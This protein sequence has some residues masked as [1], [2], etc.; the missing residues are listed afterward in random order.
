MSDLLCERCGEPWEL[1]FITDEMSE[2]ERWDFHSGKGCP[3]CKGKTLCDREYPCHECPEVM[4]GR[5]YCKL[6]LLKPRADDA[7]YIQAGLRSVLG[8]DIDGLAAEMEDLGFT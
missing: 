4:I 6:G 3:R 1:S 7:R 2:E 5:P 8:S